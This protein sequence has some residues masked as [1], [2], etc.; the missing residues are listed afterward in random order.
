M[1]TI[2]VVEPLEENTLAMDDN[3]ARDTPYIV[4]GEGDYAGTDGGG[5]Q[6]SYGHA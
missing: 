5:G 3:V 6:Y 2:T 1:A 4:A